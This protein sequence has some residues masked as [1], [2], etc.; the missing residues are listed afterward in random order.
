[1]IGASSFQPCTC[2]SYK[3]PAEIFP[4]PSSSKGVEMPPRSL[5]KR[6]MDSMVSQLLSKIGD[7]RVLGPGGPVSALDAKYVGPLKTLLLE[8]FPG[9]P[10]HLLASV[11]DD[12]I[13]VRRATLSP[14]GL[15]SYGPSTLR[16]AKAHMKQKEEWQGEYG[17]LNVTLQKSRHV[18]SD[19]E[20]AH[21][22]FHEGFF[23]PRSLKSWA[24]LGLYFARLTAS[25]E[26]LASRSNLKPN[27]VYHGRSDSHNVYAV[28]HDRNGGEVD[29]L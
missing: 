21:L 6:A 15:V 10:E 3:T 18:E 5:Q 2:V 22:I 29:A 11:R 24:K 13:V 9:L 19:L 23:H 8:A 27:N 7:A 25:M 1:M 20:D 14:S 17:V 4:L 16:L 26:E 12:L 28:L